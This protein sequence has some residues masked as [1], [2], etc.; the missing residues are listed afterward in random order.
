MQTRNLCVLLFMSG[1]LAACGSSE[2]PDTSSAP[3]AAARA[4]KSRVAATA[5]EVADEARGKVKCPAKVGTAPRAGLP[6]HDV[7]GVRPGLTWDEAM[8]VVLCTNELLVATENRGRSFRIN[9]Y[10]QT[11][12]QGFD[13]A[14]AEDR[15]NK[16]SQEIMAEMQ[17]A[18]LARGTNRR[19]PDMPGGTARWYV[20]TMGLPGKETVVA[21]ARIEAFVEGKAPTMES[22]AAAL[23]GKYGEPTQRQQQ[24]T[25][26]TFTWSYDPLDRKVTETSPLYQRCYG[27]SH[28]DA[29]VNLSPDCG[30]VVE[31]RIDSMRDN[32]L[33]ARTLQVGVVDQARGYESLVATEQQLERA[34]LERRAAA[35][36]AA[37]KQADKPTL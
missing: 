26:H 29:G 32:P 33:L 16:T 4:D 6:A 14:F 7:V 28:P 24:P 27:V 10:G 35:A 23:A 30:V 13:A 3:A 37:A 15:I 34:E 22:V 1:A 19:A 21:A 31:A 18:A 12:R 20:T 5:A 11:V 8:N 25:T 17:D 36:E 2:A 9:T